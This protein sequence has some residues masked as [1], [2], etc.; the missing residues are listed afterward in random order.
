MMVEYTT[1][2]TSM[3]PERASSATEEAPWGPARPSRMSAMLLAMEPKYTNVMLQGR[4]AKADD[5]AYGSRPTP[6]HISRSHHGRN[7]R[8]LCFSQELGH[9]I[10]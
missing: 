4:M 7:M 1:T 10:R 9:H 3:T 2:A 6:A 5:S 8:Q